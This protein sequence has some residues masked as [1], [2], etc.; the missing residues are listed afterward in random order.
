MKLRKGTRVV[1]FK[2]VRTGSPANGKKGKYIGDEDRATWLLCTAAGRLEKESF[3]LPDGYIEWDYEHEP[4]PKVN[5]GI[6]GNNPLFLLDDGTTIS[7]AQCYWLPVNLRI[8][9]RTYEECMDLLKKLEMPE[10]SLM[11]FEEYVKA[12]EKRAEPSSAE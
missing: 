4:F 2:D 8:R 1:I 12:M 11:S 6:R 7:G 9:M 10:G 3:D 5:C